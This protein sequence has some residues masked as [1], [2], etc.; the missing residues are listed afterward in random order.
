MQGHVD[1]GT[2]YLRDERR[3][4]QHHHGA[5]ADV[6]NRRA[7]ARRM[8]LLPWRHDGGCSQSPCLRVSTGTRA[9]QGAQAA[10]QREHTTVVCSAIKAAGARC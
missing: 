10:P 8:M 6:G 3:C 1:A 5:I 9:P 4:V 2:H 7:G